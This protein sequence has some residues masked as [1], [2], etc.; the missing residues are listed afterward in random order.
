MTDCAACVVA[1]ACT[2][3][4]LALRNRANKHGSQR[5]VVFVGSPVLEDDRTL[6]QLGD[7]LRKNNVCHFNHRTSPSLL[8]HV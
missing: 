5:V 1:D 8:N 2:V 4:Q 7:Q 3:V 6:K